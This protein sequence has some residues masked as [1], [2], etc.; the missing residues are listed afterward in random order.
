[1]LKEFTKNLDFYFA[2]ALSATIPN[3]PLLIPIVIALWI[4]SSFFRISS[5]K[6]KFSKYGFFLLLFFLVNLLGMTYTATENLSRGWFDIEIKLSFFLLPLLF[7]FIPK[8]SKKQVHIIINVFVLSI[9]G[10][11]IWHYLRSVFQYFGGENIYTFYGK[12]FSKPFHIGYYAMYI[13]VAFLALLSLKKSWFK[14]NN[15]IYILAF[16]ALTIGQFLTTSKIGIITF[17]GLILGYFIYQAAREGF[18][19][20]HAVLLVLTI[21]MGVFFANSKTGSRFKL[22][23][24]QFFETELSPTA[25]GS[26]QA[27]YFALKTVFT[28]IEDHWI[29]G[30]G[31]G[32]IDI[33]TQNRY[34][35]Y[36]Y[37]GAL[38]R[39]LN[40]HNQFLQT[41]AATGLLGF[42]SILAIYLSM[43][44]LS[45]KNRNQLLFGF[46][47]VCFFFALTE[48]MFETQAGIVFFTFFSLILSQNNSEYD[49]IF[50]SS[51]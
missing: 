27:R 46:T 25:E 42:L 20:Y 36:G 40:A 12:N 4:L 11:V 38:K 30:V 2:L 13:N 33:E 15:V 44:Y 17:G 45:L 51:S 18:K 10:S 31:T 26:T 6:F 14:K 9:I 34:K 43:F 48:S 50:T 29:I 49:S 28:I 3:L 5:L 1:M 7:F 39:N 22:A 41:F 16:S 37:T 21:T 24:N 19:K 47:L 32:D 23:Y 8:F 35:S